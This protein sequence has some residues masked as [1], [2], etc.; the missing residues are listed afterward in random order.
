MRPLGL[1]RGERVQ[2]SP[3]GQPLTHF[4]QIAN[5]RTHGSRSHS[6][7]VFT[8]A[9]IFHGAQERLAGGGA[10]HCLETE[11]FNSS[12]YG[13]KDSSPNESGDRNFRGLRK[14]E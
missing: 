5:N 9:I 4:H 8:R 14:V 10:T 11:T 2:T 7:A 3:H 6:Q 1:T 12:N 13:S